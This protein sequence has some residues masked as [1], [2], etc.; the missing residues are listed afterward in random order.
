MAVC[1]SMHSVYAM[2]WHAAVES[3]GPPEKPRSPQNTTGWLLS[4]GPAPASYTGSQ[5][6][7]QGLD[8]GRLLSGASEGQYGMEG[9]SASTQQQGL[10]EGRLLSG[11]SEGQY[12]MEGL[13]ASTQP[14]PIPSRVQSSLLQLPL[15]CPRH[16]AGS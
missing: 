3:L 6:E 5:Q 8:E 7:Q 9:L 11:A 16:M 10:D 1:S 4:A 15:Q 12:G 14:Q 2:L 13:S